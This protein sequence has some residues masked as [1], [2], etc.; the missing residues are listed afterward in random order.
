MGCL[1]IITAF[2]KASFRVGDRLVS[3]CV[4]QEQGRW[5]WGTRPQ[6]KSGVL[7]AWKPSWSHG[8]CIAHPLGTSFGAFA[9]APPREGEQTSQN[10]HCCLPQ[11][12]LLAPI[13][14]QLQILGFP[15]HPSLASRLVTQRAHVTLLWLVLVSLTP[16][17]VWM[18]VGFCQQVREEL[19]LHSI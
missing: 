15:H 2:I 11:G 19:K 16:I 13:K 8:L 6:H 5:D 14:A 10:W 4:R 3:T 1:G 9:L 7:V 12:L 18:C 17:W